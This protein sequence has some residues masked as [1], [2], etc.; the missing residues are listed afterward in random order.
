MNTNQTLALAIRNAAT[1]TD[2]CNAVNAYWLW[3]KGN[4]V[5]EFPNLCD[6]I[7]NELPYVQIHSVELSDET[8]NAMPPEGWLWSTESH[9]LTFSHNNNEWVV[10]ENPDYEVSSE[11]SE[12]VYANHGYCV[13]D[14][15]AVWGYGDTVELAIVDAAQW[16]DISVDAVRELIKKGESWIS[17]ASRAAIIESDGQT[18]NRWNYTGVYR[19]SIYV[20]NAEYDKLESRGR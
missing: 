6:A 11:Q 14:E 18:A 13:A 4:D 1:I 9:I 17:K 2:L 10:I 15:Q 12:D 7:Y 5:E 16:Y 19:D 8:R 3:L 20:T